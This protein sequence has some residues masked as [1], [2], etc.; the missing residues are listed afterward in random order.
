MPRGTDEGQSPR[1]HSDTL[2]QLSCV[3]ADGRRL[4]WDTS[5][6]IALRTAPMIA[7]DL[8]DTEEQPA[9]QVR[10]T[11]GPDRAETIREVRGQHGGERC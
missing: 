10:P 5:A 2:I 8:R 9:T 1:A 6:P 11:Q 4:N 3:Q 7:P